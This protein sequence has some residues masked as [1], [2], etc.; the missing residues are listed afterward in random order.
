M[1][2]DVELTASTVTNTEQGQQE[3]LDV[4][5]G[6]KSFTI[7]WNRGQIPCSE[8]CGRRIHWF[9]EVEH[10]RLVNMEINAR[11]HCMIVHL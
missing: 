9:L 2:E 4:L 8:V 7:P 5:Q 6:G 3:W 1:L 11:G 10:A